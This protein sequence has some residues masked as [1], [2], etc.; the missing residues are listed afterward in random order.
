MT[1]LVGCSSPAERLRDAAERAA[2]QRPSEE[3]G[4]SR[5]TKPSRKFAT[6]NPVFAAALESEA[7][8]MSGVHFN[9]AKTLLATWAQGRSGLMP[10]FRG[11]QGQ[12][13]RWFGLFGLDPNAIAAQ[14]YTPVGLIEPSQAFDPLIATKAAVLIFNRLSACENK[15]LLSAL[16]GVPAMSNDIGNVDS[17][18]YTWQ[19]AFDQLHDNGYLDGPH[20]QLD[21]PECVRSI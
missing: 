16:C 21:T 20:L 10:N 11:G 6:E 15:Q 12:E 7:V 2:P 19:L 9:R 1:S 17:E 13:G 3:I 5:N 4:L 8:N 14:A 18:L